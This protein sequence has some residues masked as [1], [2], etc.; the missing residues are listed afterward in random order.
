MYYIYVHRRIRTEGESMKIK[1]LIKTMQGYPNQDEDI[2]VAWWER[3][4][5]EEWIERKVTDEQWGNAEDT[6]MNSDWEEAD[7]IIKDALKEIK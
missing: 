2:I 7:T 6:L 5:V 1:D 4:V 3:D